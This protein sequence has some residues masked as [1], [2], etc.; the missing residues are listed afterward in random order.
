MITDVDITQYYEVKEE[1]V[2]D[3]NILKKKKK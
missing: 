2:I 3:K 1:D